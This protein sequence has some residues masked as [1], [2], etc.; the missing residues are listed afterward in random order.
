M[1]SEVKVWEGVGPKIGL[2]METRICTKSPR[3]SFVG[4]YVVEK[5]KESTQ[6][7]HTIIVLR[8]FY[9]LLNV[10]STFFSESLNASTF[11]EYEKSQ[12]LKTW[13]GIVNY[14]TR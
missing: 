9:K 7:C 1:A 14:T 11:D 13:K 2:E 12:S 8:N 6:T 5:Y 4:P 3:L 10:S